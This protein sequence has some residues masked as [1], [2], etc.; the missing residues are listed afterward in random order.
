MAYHDEDNASGINWVIKRTDPSRRRY[1]QKYNT[2]DKETLRYCKTCRFVWEYN[3]VK[4]R[5]RVDHEISKY[6]DFPTR[7]IRRCECPTCNH[8]QH[9]GQVVICQIN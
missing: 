4:H 3:P 5:K 2:K 7:G 1:P 9:K 6:I 8:K